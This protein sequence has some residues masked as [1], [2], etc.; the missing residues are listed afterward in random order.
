MQRP[1]V[2][3]FIRIGAD[4]THERQR[5]AVGAEQDVLAVVEL[6]AVY[7]DAPSPATENAAGFEQRRFSAGSSQLDGGCNARPAA[8]DDGDFQGIRP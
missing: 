8:T 3:E 6:V 1:P 2:E 5:I 7:L 4:L